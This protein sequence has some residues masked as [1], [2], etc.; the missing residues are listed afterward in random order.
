MKSG[1]TLIEIVLV[2]AILA[3]AGT[4][5]AFGFTN[6]RRAKELEHDARAIVAYL[7]DAQQRSMTQ[8]GGAAWGVRFEN[9]ADPGQDYYD[10][11]M[12]AHSQVVRH[13][14]LR[15]SVEFAIPAA[16]N[17]EDVRFERLSGELQGGGGVPMV[18]VRIRGANCASEPASCSA[19][20]VCRSG[21]VTDDEAQCGGGGDDG[22]GRE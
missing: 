21:V 2:I 10:L 14:V 16:N 8:D 13:V 3:I 20:F 5:A 12:N 17:Y 19:V 22:E 9:V 1:F 18:Q 7:R 6:A 15:P 11:Y 4:F